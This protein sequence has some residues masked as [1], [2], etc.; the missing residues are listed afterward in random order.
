MR[1]Y[2]PQLGIPHMKCGNSAY[3]SHFSQVAGRRALPLLS[4]N[5]GGERW[6]LQV[7]NAFA[8]D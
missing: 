5:H 3:R 4:V 2:V 8:V 6:G 1:E 7:V